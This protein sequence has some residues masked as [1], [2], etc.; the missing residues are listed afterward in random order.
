MK[1]EQIAEITNTMF[2][3]VTGIETLQT[4]NL[5]YID[6][7]REVFN[8][9]G[10]DNYVNTL[11]DHIGKVVFK[12]K[13]YQPKFSFL[14][15]DA[16]E[17]GAVKEKIRMVYDNE[18]EINDS[19]NL[20]DGT[21]YNQDI[22]YKPSVTVKFFGNK[23]TFMIPISIAE[24]QVKSAFS[25]ETQLNSFFSMIFSAIKEQID[26]RIDNLAIRV[27]NS[28]IAHTMY[29]TFKNTVF[30]PTPS[31]NLSGLTGN[32]KCIN[33]L[34]LYK[35]LM[36]L[37]DELS[38]EDA[39]YNKEFLRFAGQFILKTTDRMTISNEQFNIGKVINHTE[40]EEQNLVLLSD[41]VRAL[42]SYLY[43]DTFNANYV[44]VGNYVTVP[45]WQGT[46]G[47]V[48]DEIARINVVIKDDDGTTHTIDLNESHAEAYVL[49][50]LFDRDAC[51]ISN[52]NN[53]VTTHYNARADF[54]NNY[55]KTDASY[56]NDLNENFVVFFIA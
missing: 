30:K 40:R 33:L 8:Q 43:S 47:F 34:K 48:L 46:K 27:I 54:T 24:Y 25:N 45:Y 16:W 7:G 39:L 32:V 18:A 35:N 15:K 23:E 4:E 22:F 41:F 55:F 6:K 9:L 10:F 11:I 28:A 29:D 56:W 26:I 53:R 5:S 13:S 50:V 31:H 19:W 17:F 21:T 14:I 49:G 44:K 42:E 12:E 36:N 37:T 20:V 2:E 51:G 38:I 1:V 3:E 52:G